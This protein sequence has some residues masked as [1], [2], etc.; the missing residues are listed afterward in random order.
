MNK[1]IQLSARRDFAEI[2]RI[3]Q[4]VARFGRAHHLPPQIVFRVNL[5]LEELLTNVI[6]YGYP[7]KV[8]GNEEIRVHLR[9][10]DDGLT[11]ELRDNGCAFNPLDAPPP[12]LDLPLEK[13]PIGGLGIHFVLSVMDNVRYRREGD[14]NHITMRHGWPEDFSMKADPRGQ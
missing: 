11:T 5:A 8:T 14:F 1:Q 13:K 6:K 3:N 4:V 12:D 9:L 7:E 10:D 2:H